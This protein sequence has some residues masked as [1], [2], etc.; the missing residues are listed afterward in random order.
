MVSR[1]PAFAK[2]KLIKDVG[3]LAVH[4]HKPVRDTDAL[5][6]VRELFLIADAG[7]GFV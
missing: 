2:A 1:Q 6:V 7:R 5:V 4:T 3:N